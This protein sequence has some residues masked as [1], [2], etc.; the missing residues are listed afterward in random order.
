MELYNDFNYV[1]Y[2][3]ELPFDR[4]FVLYKAA[5]DK[6]KFDLDEKTKDRLFQIWLLECQNGNK[7]SF[8]KFLEQNKI[9]TEIDNM[10]KDEKISMEKD[11]IDRV[12]NDIKNKKFKRRNKVDNY[13]K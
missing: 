11:I 12:T 3:L 2:I 1:N 8:D 6:I 4:G 7:I 9:K 10:T 13:I 5:I